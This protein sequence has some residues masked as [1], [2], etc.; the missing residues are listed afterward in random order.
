MA[1]K[2]SGRLLRAARIRQHLSREQLAVRAGISMCAEARYERGHATPGV[3]T[4]VALADALGVDLAGL[5]EADAGPAA[6]GI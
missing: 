3:N 6:G 1:R 2:F 5:L 4:A